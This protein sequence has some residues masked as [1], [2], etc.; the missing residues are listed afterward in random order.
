MVNRDGT[1]LAQVPQEDV[2]KVVGRTLRGRP[3]P[4]RRR[5]L[6]AEGGNVVIYDLATGARRLLVKTAAAE[7]SPRWA[8]GGTAVT[9]MRDGNLFLLAL[10]AR[11]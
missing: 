10:D 6:T 5:L 7:S 8:R 2:R 11:G 3:D 1:G 4:E 9:F